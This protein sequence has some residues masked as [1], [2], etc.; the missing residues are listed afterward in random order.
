MMN[1]FPHPPALAVTRILGEAGLPYSDLTDAH[2]EHFFGCGSISAPDGIV[3][4]ELYESV[5]LLR[6]LAV[7]SKCRGRGCGTA[8]VAQAELFAQ[9][10][11]AREICLLTTAAERFFEQ[12]GYARVPREAAPVVI[13]RT[14][15]FSTLCP[16]D[17][18]FMVKRLPVKK[19]SAIHEA[20]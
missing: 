6:S 4:L 3:G 8:L 13:Q 5:A 15:E 9:S 19:S 12:L 14:Q 7:S 1:V 2:L 10:Q 18:A 16:S 20:H 11:G 17:S